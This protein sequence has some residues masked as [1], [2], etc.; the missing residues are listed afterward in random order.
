[1]MLIHHGDRV[2]THHGWW[3]GLGGILPSI[4]LLVLIG[5]TIWAVLRT[6]AR[7]PILAAGAGSS[8]L[9]GRKDQAIEEVRLRYARGEMAR[10][11]FVQRSRD[12]GGPELEPGEPIAP[13]SG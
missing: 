11:E 9:S 10:E 8:G 12:L 3:W 5:V 2:F 7:G 1:M 4:L 13:P 6:T